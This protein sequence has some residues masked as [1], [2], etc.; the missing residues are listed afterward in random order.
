MFHDIQYK[1]KDVTTPAGS[2]SMPIIL[3][4]SCHGIVDWTIEAMQRHYLV[5]H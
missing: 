2:P 3:M 4:H 1:G 5:G